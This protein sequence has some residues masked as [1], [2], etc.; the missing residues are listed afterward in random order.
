MWQNCAITS[1]PS[2]AVSSSDDRIDVYLR[3][4]TSHTLQWICDTCHEHEYTRVTHAL[5]PFTY[6]RD[7]DT[8][9]CHSRRI[10][11][12]DTSGNT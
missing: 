12:E 6:L 11:D 7:R 1:E 2:P 8:S 9:E 10:N 4:N 5:N 3:C